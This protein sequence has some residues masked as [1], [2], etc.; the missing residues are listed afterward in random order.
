VGDKH[1]LDLMLSRLSKIK[2]LPTTDKALYLHLGCGV[3][4]L[5]GF[6]NVDK[7]VQHPGVMQADMYDVPLPEKSV[8]A[9]YSSHALEHLPIRHAKMALENWAKILESNGML[10]LA[11]PD[12]EAIMRAMLDANVS[13]QAK[14][15][16]YIY[17]LFGY[18]IEPGLKQDNPDTPVCPGQFH[19]CGFTKAYLQK[20]LTSAGFKVTEIFDYDGWDTPSIYIEARRNGP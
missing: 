2:A 5:D 11:V 1:N 18:Q 20:L 4:V 9:I 15:D 14:W 12:L 16:W 19:T 3:H 7:Y 13:D 17:T 10:Y 8:R 6:L